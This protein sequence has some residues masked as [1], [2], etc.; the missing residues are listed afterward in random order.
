VNC[1]VSGITGRQDICLVY[2]GSGFKLDYFRFVKSPNAT[3]QVKANSQLKIYPNPATDRLYVETPD[4]GCL[5]VYDVQGKETSSFYVT[6][7][8]T[9]FPVG[10]YNAGI[11]FV[12]LLTDK[13]TSFAR[14][15]KL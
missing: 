2:R 10:D 7:G 4:K 13:G 14:F 9:N 12:H 11:Y 8:E 6:A 15:L 3:D 5:S 1:A